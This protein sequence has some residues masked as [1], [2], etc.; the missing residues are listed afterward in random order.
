MKL[1]FSDLKVGDTVYCVYD[2]KHNNNDN[3]HDLTI[4]KAKVMSNSLE[5][6]E[7]GSSSYYDNDVQVFHEWNMIIQP[8]KLNEEYKRYYNKFCDERAQMTI[9]AELYSNNPSLE[10]F[11]SKEDA[12]EYAIS[13]MNQILLRNIQNINKLKTYNEQIEKTL[14]ELDNYE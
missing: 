4:I 11:V 14:N 6:R 13:F 1:K 9:T 12:K 7:I 8:E 10:I 3:N 2:K 5:K